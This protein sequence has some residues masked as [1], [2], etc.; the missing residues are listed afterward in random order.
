MYLH[1][2]PRGLATKISKKHAERHS[3]SSLHR[4]LNSLPGYIRTVP[5]MTAFQRK[6][7]TGFPLSCLQK[8]FRTFPGPQNVFP[9]LCRSPAMLNY[10]QTAVTS[11]YIQCNSTI[12][13]KMFITSCKETVRLAHSRNT[14]YIY[15]HMV[16]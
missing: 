2:Y 3:H 13:R 6:L 15:L 1:R 9:G 4:R 5:S 11:L 16:F 10:S 7:K 14:L 12:H 8:N